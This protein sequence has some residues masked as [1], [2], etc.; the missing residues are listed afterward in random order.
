[1]ET[2]VSS[3]RRLT[4]AAGG[5]YGK[6]GTSSG[7]DGDG[8]AMFRFRLM[9]E[10]GEDAGEFET[11]APTW[12]IGDELYDRDHRRLRVAGCVD[13]DGTRFDGLLVVAPIGAA[14]PS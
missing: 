14:G 12:E 3:A 10:T 6:V 4:R 11:A 8:G 2:A 7:P 9:L 1:M 5:S 13:L